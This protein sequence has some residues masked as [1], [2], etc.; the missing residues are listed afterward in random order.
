MKVIVHITKDD[1]RKDVDRV[2]KA[3]GDLG[4]EVTVG[5]KR[6]LAAA[7]IKAWLDRQTACLEETIS[8]PRWPYA[9]ESTEGLPSE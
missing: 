2:V 6:M 1:N 5:N 7:T 3:V 4:V 9:T 8:D